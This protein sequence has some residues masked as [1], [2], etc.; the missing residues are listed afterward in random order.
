MLVSLL[1]AATVSSAAKKGTFPALDKK[2][3]VCTFAVDKIRIKGDR[4]AGAAKFYKK[5][6]ACKGPQGYAIQDCQL[7]KCQCRKFHTHVDVSTNV[8]TTWAECMPKIKDATECVGADYRY[9]QNL[10][11]GK[12][13]LSKSAA[14]STKYGRNASDAASSSS[15]STLKE[16]KA[17]SAE[18]KSLTS[19]STASSINSTDKKANDTASFP[20]VAVVLVSVGVIGAVLGGTWLVVSKKKASKSTTTMGV[21]GGGGG[22]NNKAANDL[23]FDDFEDED[24]KDLYT[25]AQ[26]TSAAV[27]TVA[28]PACSH[29]TG[30]I[31]SVSSSDES[32]DD[33]DATED[34]AHLDSWTSYSKK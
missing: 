22:G 19:G 18:S 34:A 6:K 26:S 14:G 17:S 13:P 28:P 27:H 30:S 24:H 32:D 12:D 33:D 7:K 23:E 10:L 25:D 3:P 16:S 11:R 29:S 5:S 1:F 2:N 4:E 15:S 9:C 20:V 21:H 31:S 8:V